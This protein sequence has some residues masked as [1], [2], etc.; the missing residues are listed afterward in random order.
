MSQPLAEPS[1]IERTIKLCDR[2]LIRAAKADPANPLLR[3]LAPRNQP[4]HFAEQDPK[5][6]SP[7]NL[8]SQA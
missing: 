8:T 7:S 5:P 2:A 1:W 6:R 3:D 4:I